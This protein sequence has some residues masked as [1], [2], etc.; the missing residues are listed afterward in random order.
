MSRRN[1][2]GGSIAFMTALSVH[3]IVNADETAAAVAEG[4]E[5]I[6]QKRERIGVELEGAW[7]EQIAEISKRHT[8]LMTRCGAVIGALKQKKM[9]SSIPAF[10]EEWGKIVHQFKTVGSA[11][12]AQLDMYHAMQNDMEKIL[13]RWE[14]WDKLLIPPAAGD[15]EFFPRYASIIA[16]RKKLANDHAI[17]ILTDGNGKFLHNYAREKRNDPKLTHAEYI[18][19][20]ATVL[21]TPEN[22]AMY[23][24]YYV[25]Y[26]YDSPTSDW[27][28]EGTEANNGEYWQSAAETLERMKDG[29]LLGDCE[30]QAAL[31]QAVLREMG[32]EAMLVF[33]P[34]HIT[35]AWIEK[36]ASGRYDG[37]D[38]G[39]FGL[40]K[41]G[42]GYGVKDG[43]TLGTRYLPTQRKEF[44]DGY[45]TP[46]DAF[47]SVMQKFSR[48]PTLGVGTEWL[49]RP[50]FSLAH[51]V[52]GKN[53]HG[54]HQRTNGTSY[55][56]RT[57]LLKHV[58]MPKRTPIVNASR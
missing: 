43:I 1:F 29:W 36:N 57:D 47:T 2:L 16:R 55:L 50:G 51:I 58:R 23:L 10:N 11:A 49:E 46:S 31:A 5:T 21:E 45:A 25:R 9:E 26:A 8:T 37:Y 22:L 7:N 53:A 12:L 19:R 42:V 17:A 56:A 20:L 32:I 54:I 24:R 18:K 35:C 33:M 30:D 41:N 34:R 48:S 3:G 4:P 6:Q 13:D 27:K 14:R 15:P 39:N 40:E 28:A 52:D 44:V 38:I